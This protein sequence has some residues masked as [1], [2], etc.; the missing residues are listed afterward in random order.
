MAKKTQKQ[1]LK[2]WIDAWEK[3]DRSN[4]FGMQVEMEIN[5]SGISTFDVRNELALIKM[6]PIEFITDDDRKL[7]DFFGKANHIREMILQDSVGRNVK[8]Q[9]F[10]LQS[11]FGYTT[12]QRVETSGSQSVVLDFGGDTNE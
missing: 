9:I 2:L 1:I 10:L 6:K 3:S 7:L 12:T 5:K 4:P 11:Q 8:G